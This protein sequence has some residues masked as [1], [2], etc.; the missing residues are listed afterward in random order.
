MKHVS[1]RILLSIVVQEDLELEQLDVKTAFLHGELQEKIYM[2]PPEGYESQ[3]KKNEVCLL[4]K[5]LYGLKQAPRQWNENLGNYMTE[6]GFARGSYDNCAYVK[7]LHDGSRIYLLLY[8]ATCLWLRK[9]C[10]I[11]LS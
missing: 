8:V 9:I 10:K 4:K 6:I 1:V 2:T 5:S 3:F 7:V 11:L